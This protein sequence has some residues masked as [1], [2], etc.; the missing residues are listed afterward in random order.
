MICLICRQADTVDAQTSVTL[1]RGEYKIVID[2]VPAY[3]CPNCGEAYV[4]EA[5]AARL[6]Q[7]AEEVCLSGELNAVREYQSLL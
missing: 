3:M 6:L 5:V 4:D 2:L 1:V 7:G